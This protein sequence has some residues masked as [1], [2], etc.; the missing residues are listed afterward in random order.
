MQSHVAAG[1]LYIVPEMPQYSYPIYAVKSVDA[2]ETV[3]GPA[4]AGLHS[5]L[6]RSVE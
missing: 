3:V 6:N 1:Q 5:I 2:D 4:L